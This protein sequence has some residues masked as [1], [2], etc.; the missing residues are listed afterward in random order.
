MSLCVPHLPGLLRCSLPILH[1]FLQ[2]GHAE[3]QQR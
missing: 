3:Q 2:T 1:S